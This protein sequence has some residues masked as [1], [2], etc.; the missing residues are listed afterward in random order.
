[1][2]VFKHTLKNFKHQQQALVILIFTL[3]AAMIW[4]SA[5]LFNSQ[6]K[7]GISDEQLKLSK[8]LT[9]TIDEKT[10]LRLEQKQAYSN[11]EL[12]QFPIYMILKDKS[13]IET[14]VEIG[15]QPEPTP[16]PK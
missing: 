16:L 9:P 2:N 8:P 15:T 13:Q 1:M 7:L 5:S 4:I 12:S 11:Q 6:R 3:I 10:L 14:I